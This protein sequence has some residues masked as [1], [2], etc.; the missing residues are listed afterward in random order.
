MYFFCLS[1]EPASHPA[2][3]PN[4][5]S[6]PPAPSNSP[7][8]SQPDDKTRSNVISRTWAQSRGS[9]AEN[10]DPTQSSRAESTA[11]GLRPTAGGPPLSCERE[12]KDAQSAGLDRGPPEER[13]SMDFPYQL[14]MRGPGRDELNRACARDGA[15]SGGRAGGG[16]GAPRD[17]FI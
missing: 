9:N 16:G 6:T 1:V 10:Q 15:T 12:R 17:T 11:H 7:N 14:R 13:A 3:L 2:S 5:S 4:V 8:P